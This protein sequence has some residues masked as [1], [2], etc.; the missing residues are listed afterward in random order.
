M[1]MLKFIARIATYLVCLMLIAPTVISQAEDDPLQH[2][3]YEIPPRWLVD[4][5]TAGTLPRGYYDIVVRMYANG[6]ALS[7]TNIGL[8]NRFMI[9]ISFGGENIISARG[10]NW[11]PRIGFSLRFRVI[12]ELEFFPA[13]SVGYSG[14]G[15][16]TY[17]DKT[18]RYQFKSRGFYAVASRS[19]YFYR[20][21]SGWHGGINYSLENDDTDE[22]LNFFAGIDATFNYNLAMLLEYDIALNDNKGGAATSITG[23]GRGYLNFSIKWLFTNSLELELIAKDLLI[24]RRES[25]EFSREVRFTFIDSF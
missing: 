8:S 18:K 9:G 16:G 20:W 21:T 3:L 25:S 7:Y 4:V 24:N 14:Q 19:F 2:T 13:V 1:L 23:K 17:D 12:D 11:N 15:I 22:D 5:P 10:V 6:G